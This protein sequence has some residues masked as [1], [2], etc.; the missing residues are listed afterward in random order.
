MSAARKENLRTSL[1]PIKAA[2]FVCLDIIFSPVS[3]DFYY[4]F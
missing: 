1:K 3:S 2:M 4:K